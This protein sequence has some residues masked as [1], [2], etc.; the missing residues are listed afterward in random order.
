MLSLVFG[1]SSPDEGVVEARPEVRVRAVHSSQGQ[2]ESLVALSD[3][4][5]GREE[6]EREGG[7]VGKRNEML[8]T[9]ISS[10]KMHV[11]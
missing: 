7:R 6:G 3:T 10:S 2:Q 1:E 8:H 4:R 11:H 9:P 5:G